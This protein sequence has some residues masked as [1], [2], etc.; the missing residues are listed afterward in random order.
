MPRDMFGD[1]VNPSIRVGSQKR[2]TVPLSI[3]VHVVIIARGADHPPDGD[4]HPA[5]SAVD[6]GVRRRAAA[7]TASTAAASGRG[8]GAHDEADSVGQSVRGAY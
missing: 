1:V 8:P 4:G 5:D 6:D 2:Y 3:L 7:A